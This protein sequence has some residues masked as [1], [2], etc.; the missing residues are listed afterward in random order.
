VLRAAINHPTVRDVRV[1]A[2]GIEADNLASRRCAA[3]AASASTSTSRTGR[4]SLLPPAPTGG[5]EPEDAW[6]SDAIEILSDLL[7][8]QFTIDTYALRGRF[9]REVVTM[10][11]RTPSRLPQAL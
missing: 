11:S 9:W 3:A 5:A 6:E 2:A 8:A 10:D 4:A 7:Q 1:F